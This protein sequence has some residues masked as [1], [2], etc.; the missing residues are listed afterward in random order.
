M[1]DVIWR[2]TV[3]PSGVGTRRLGNP[4]SATELEPVK[5]LICHLKCGYT[6]IQYI[7]R[8]QP[9]GLEGTTLSYWIRVL[10]EFWFKMCIYWTLLFQP[11]STTW[12]INTFFWTHIFLSPFWTLPIFFLLSEQ[13]PLWILILDP[14][15]PSPCMNN[16]TCE[17][18]EE[19][20]NITYVCTCTETTTGENCETGK[21]S[22]A[23]IFLAL[24]ISI[25]N[26]CAYEFPFVSATRYQRS[27]VLF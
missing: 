5:L 12:P 24:N 17:I 15:N 3:C 18:T 22:A 19:S 1:V 4:A 20:G 26:I 6:S 8:H 11:L 10:F 27:L 21:G 14:C 23:S 13:P 2:S 16:G 9:R 7:W 25:G